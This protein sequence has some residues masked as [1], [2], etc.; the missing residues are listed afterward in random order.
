M[1]HFIEHMLFKGT[2][3]RTAKQIAETLE[4][5]GGHINAFT[6]REQTCYHVRVLDEYLDRAVDVLADITCNSTFTSVN[7]K[8]E[9]QVILEE[10]KEAFENPADRIHD[11]FAEA[12]WGGHPLGQPILGP[13]ENVFGFTRARLMKYLHRH[14]QTGSIV[15]AAAGNVSHE[16]LLR[17]VRN[18]FAFE[19]GDGDGF[20][21]ADR[22]KP[23]QFHFVGPGSGNSQTHLCIGFPGIGYNSRL[24]MPVL[25]LNAYLG[26]GMSSVVFHKIR[27]VKGLAYSVYTYAD[28]Y[29]DSG[30]FGAYAGTDK[31]HVHQALDII[32]TE[33]NRL[34]RRR[35]PSH[36]LDTIKAQL[37]GQIMLGMES[38]TA[39]MNRLG[40]QELY[41]GRFQSFSDTLDNIE[42]VS[43][44]DLLEFANQSFD[45]SQLTVSVLGPA[46]RREIRNTVGK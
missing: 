15:V 14:Y 12:F 10:I 45:D 8:R 25:V 13:A 28:F 36:K 46:S 43:S 4:S 11:E 40:R 20:V 33:M 18:Q 24:K 30:I 19:S 16:R 2:Q 41:S 31:K 35:L 44:S 42:K 9:K 23:R 6:S 1:S 26:G 37:K 29:R 22:P 3:K 34:K 32:L 7:I 21:P 5:I 39:R 38:T 27:E 17:L